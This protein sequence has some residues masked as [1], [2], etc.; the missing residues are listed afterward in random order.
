MAATR[1]KL[2]AIGRL[3]HELA[4]LPRHLR[5]RQ[6][7][8]IE[9]LAEFVEPAKSY[10]YTLVC[11]HITGF[12][13]VANRPAEAL[14]GQAL[15]EDLSELA[16]QLS[17]LAGI[18]GETLR[19]PLWTQQQLAER[20]KVSA[21]TLNRWR[22]R[23]LMAWRVE[24][25]GKPDRLIFTERAVRRFVWRHGRL[26]CRGRQFSQLSAKEKGTIIHRARELGLAEP[27]AAFYLIARQI[28]EET[29]RAVETIR[30]TLRRH[31]R[32]H[33]DKAVFDRLEKLP[34]PPT[35]GDVIYEEYR[36]GTPVP[37]LAVRFGRTRS[38]V[39]RML[40]EGRA[41][42]LAERRIDYMYSQEFELP[43]ADAWILG[44][45]DESKDRRGKEKLRVPKNVPAFLEHLYR[46]PLLS[47][48]Q[49][50]DLFRCYNYLKFK[51]DRLRDQIDP[52]KPR[53]SQLDA[54]EN[55][56]AQSE[57][58]RA[59]IIQSNLRLVVSV[60]KRHMG[61]VV[62]AGELVSDG[63]LAL[64]RAVEKFD[65][66]RGYK[67]STY[68]TWA[69]M[70]NYARS[71]PE[72]HYQHERF[73]TGREELLKLAERHRIEE[74]PQEEQ[75]SGAREAVNRLLGALSE[76]E[77]LIVTRHYGLTEAGRKQTLEQIGH[78]LGVTKERVR[79]LEQR[80][81]RKLRDA[82]GEA[83]LSLQG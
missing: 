9:R 19:Q 28:A 42:R 34:A 21:K 47:R 1:Y 23:G 37:E 20:F 57:Q 4:I 25:E 31:D 79:Q 10:P 39:Y 38:T 33:P 77:R 51:A 41:K 53:G 29:G 58:M 32:Q 63:N 30:Y 17:Q 55:L 73:Q 13:G 67:F 83:D 18:G 50:W 40:N 14:P 68:A 16:E 81:L 62:G 72:E 27:G 52:A 46:T 61:G 11:Y 54:V 76:R 7:D 80:A 75:A 5:L 2:E 56:L 69:V 45:G 65:Y 66:T 8:G 12:A 15:L 49:E 48:G 78:L 60:A 64:M 26:V 36:R 82:A 44:A 35:M 71:I 74:E 70:K 22:S 24:L 59:R 6:L 43:D 3:A